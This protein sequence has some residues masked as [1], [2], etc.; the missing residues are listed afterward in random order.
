MSGVFTRIGVP[1]FAGLLLIFF[2]FFRGPG[3]HG[4][5]RW[6]GLILALLGLAGLIVARWTLGKSFSVTPQARRL[7]THGIYSKLR[8]PIYVS[9]AV[10]LAGVLLMVQQNYLWI[11][12]GLLLAVQVVR[13]R[14]ESRVLEAKFGDQYREW[15]KGTWF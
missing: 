4:P 8:N 3:P 14:Q 1:L 6:M 5:L 12:W 9:G 2:V 7:V 13:A 10:C 11:A 15:R